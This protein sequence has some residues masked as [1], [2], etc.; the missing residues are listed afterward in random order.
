MLS[1]PDS[2]S[3]CDATD[4]P[5][6]APQADP[7]LSAGNTGEL[8]RFHGTPGQRACRYALLQL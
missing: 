8:E 3:T 6:S 7:T 4:A 5:T 2:S 1:L